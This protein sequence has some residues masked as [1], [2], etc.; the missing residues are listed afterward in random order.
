[1]LAMLEEIDALPDGD[2]RDVLQLAALYH[3]AIYDPRAGDNEEASAALLIAHALDPASAVVVRA[4]ELILAS[5]W[6]A[7]PATPLAEKFFALDTAQLAD[8]CPIHERL[9]Y[10]RAIFREY[11]WAAWP[12]YREKRWEFLEGW[13]ERFPQHRR[14]VAE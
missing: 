14:G 4:A 5:K 3:D 2:E 1:M 9:A 8:G 13:A 7:P 12:A 11:Q 6:A 10:E